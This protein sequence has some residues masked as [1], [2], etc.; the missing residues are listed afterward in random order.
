MQRTI[1]VEGKPDAFYFSSLGCLQTLTLGSS[2]LLPNP[3][4]CLVFK[5]LLTLWDPLSFLWVFHAVVPFPQLDYLL[6]FFAALF[7]GVDLSFNVSR[8][9]LLVHSHINHCS[10]PPL[11]SASSRR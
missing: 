6:F 5:P 4:V 8:F 11:S 3:N 9:T 7:E 2:R 1:S 10:L